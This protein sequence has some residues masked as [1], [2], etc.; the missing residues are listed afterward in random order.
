MK[1]KVT[2]RQKK[3]Y[4]KM[5]NG[6]AA[7]I[8]A[9]GGAATKKRGKAYF[10]KI[11]GQRKTFGGGRPRKEV[12]LIFDFAKQ[13]SMYRGLLKDKSLVDIAV[14][15]E[16]PV[17]R[18]TLLAVPLGGSRVSGNL[19]CFKKREA[20]LIMAILLGKNGFEDLRARKV[21]K[22]FIIEWGKTVLPCDVS[23]P[24]TA[25]LAVLAGRMYGYKESV[26]A[27]WVK[28]HYVPTR[29][30]K[31]KCSQFIPMGKNPLFCAGC[32]LAR[33]EHKDG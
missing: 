25:P 2:K 5:A 15:I 1:R 16:V 10:R 29:P 19:G 9:I 32:G 3:L 8:G 14:R 7:K 33:F 31:V 12:P 13:C 6:R 11:S 24:E 18:A 26:I 17:W 21:R 4:D 28:K 22:C 23:V 30:K 27:K 20:N